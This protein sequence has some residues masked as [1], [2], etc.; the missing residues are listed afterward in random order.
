MGIAKM[1]DAKFIVL[2]TLMYAEDNQDRFP[3]SF[4][5]I[6]SYLGNKTGDLEIPN[7]TGTNL[8][9]I[10]YQ[11]TRSSVANPASV[12]VIREKLA[13]QT[14]SGRWARTY[15]FVDGHSEVHSSD[16][17]NFEPWEKQHMISAPSPGQ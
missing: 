4:E 8:F 17:G 5:Q 12:I 13:W 7:P 11:G 16:D 6:A 1:N 2:G 10:V 14:A 9:E 15:G 3:T